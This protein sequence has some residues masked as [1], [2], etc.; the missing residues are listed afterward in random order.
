M[1]NKKQTLQVLAKMPLWNE[2][3][4]AQCC[5]FI[6]DAVIGD[7]EQHMLLGSFDLAIR[8]LIDRLKNVPDYDFQFSKKTEKVFNGMSEAFLHGNFDFFQK[9]PGYTETHELAPNEFS[10]IPLA[11]EAFDGEEAYLFKFGTQWRFAWRQWETKK[12]NCIS[13]DRDEFIESLKSVLI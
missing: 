12:V 11:V 2:R 9:I 13:L 8:D 6:G 3:K 7:F 1:E 5:F 10:A 4:F